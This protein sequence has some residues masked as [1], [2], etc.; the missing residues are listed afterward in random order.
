MVLDQ[1][2]ARGRGYKS[3]SSS[4][5]ITVQEGSRSRPDIKAFKIKAPRSMVVG[6]EWSRVRIT[7]RSWSAEECLKVRMF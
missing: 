1:L 7:R 3:R 6:L 5:K 4:L 2:Q